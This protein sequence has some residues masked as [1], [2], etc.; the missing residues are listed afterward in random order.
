MSQQLSILNATASEV[1]KTHTPLLIKLCV[2]V[3][4]QPH[5]SLLQ[6]ARN[7]GMFAECISLAEVHA[8]I[9]SGFLE[10]DI[11]LTGPGKF[12]NTSK[13]H[14]RVLAKPLKC[15]FADSLSDLQVIVSRVL[16]PHDVLDCHEIGI[17]FAPTLLTGYSRFGIDCSDILIVTKCVTLIKSLQSKKKLSVQFHFASSTLG[18]SAWF[19]LAE[20][21]VF[22]CSKFLE[23]C[24][25]PLHTLDLGGG[26][27]PY[28]LHDT[29]N[30]KR[31]HVLF[32]QICNCFPISHDP[33]PYVQFELG[34]CISEMSGGIITS[35][36]GVRETKSNNKVH[37]YHSPLSCV[38][39]DNETPKPLAC[40]LDTCVAEI[41]CPHIHPIFWMSAENVWVQL[42]PGK[43]QLWGRTCME[44]DRLWAGISL[45]RNLKVGD[46]FLI[47]ATGSYDFSNSYD[48]G[49][50][51]AREMDTV[52]L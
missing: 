26:W 7:N 50:G 4:T 31:M 28:F 20:S 43:D 12:W 52:T 46:L 8:A 10:K 32:T 9:D 38:A 11:V 27:S 23:M 42:R 1:S 37:G 35:V 25:V 36:L 41:S 14:E 49:D 34:K 16:D 47:G 18:S 51:V 21:F 19:G 2:S 33:H 30:Q 39:L 5:T 3:K 15:I 24:E 22:F 29:G 40:I 13:Y 44:F 17:R 45:P 48:F 6:A